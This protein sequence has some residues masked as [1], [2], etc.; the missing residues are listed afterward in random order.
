MKLFHINND[1]TRLLIFFA[2][3][4]T[5]NNCFMEFDNKKSDILFIYDYS[6]LNFDEIAYFDFTPYVEINLIAYSY[7]VFAANLAADFLP[8]INNSVAISGT[9]FPIDENY[10]IK[11]KI[12]DLMLN[13]FNLDVIQNFKNKMEMNSGGIIQNSKREIENLKSEL[14][15]IKNFV[16][17]NEIKENFEFSK[18][19]ITKKDRIIPYLAQKSFW[20]GHRNVYEL[21][22][23]HFP[24]FNFKNFDE[25]LE[26]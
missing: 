6:D 8:E 5:D 23:G 14:M 9:I 1:S 19:I 22:L 17:N 16:L 7:G 13:S 3:F 18:V 4:Y 20:E 15:N 26:L 10:G 2:G 25:I 24:F 21:D 11:P 12:Y